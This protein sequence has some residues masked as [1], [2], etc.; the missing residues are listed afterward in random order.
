MVGTGLILWAVKERQKHAKVL[1]KGGR[2]SF[3]LR[4]VDGLNLGTIAGV[5]IA[6]ASYFWANRLLP[7]ELADRPAMEAAM[8]FT[9]WGIAAVL[10]LAW[11]AR[12]MWQVLLGVGGVMFAGLPVL[13]AF[14]TDS[15]LGYSLAHGL[16]QIASFDIVVVLLGALLLFAAKRMGT[17]RGKNKPTATD[18]TTAPRESRE[19]TAPETVMAT[20]GAA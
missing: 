2:V 10:A 1:A 3:G 17:A 12:R 20:G 4:L 8:F 18:K 19:A 13:N 9:G 14:T 11:P 7:V 16:T 15:H 5:P 6:L